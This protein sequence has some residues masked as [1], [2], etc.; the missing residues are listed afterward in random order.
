MRAFAY[1]LGFILGLQSWE[2]LLLWPGD[3]MNSSQFRPGVNSGFAHLALLCGAVA[4]D[5]CDLSATERL[6]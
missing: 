1:E 6:C 2:R 5:F 3:N 4:A